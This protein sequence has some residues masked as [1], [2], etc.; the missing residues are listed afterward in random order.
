MELGARVGRKMSII[1]TKKNVQNQ[2]KVAVKTDL[3]TAD[4]GSIMHQAWCYPSRDQMPDAKPEASTART[5]ETKT[6]SAGKSAK[7]LY[8]AHQNASSSH[9][10][11]REVRSVRAP[12]GDGET[13]ASHRTRGSH[14]TGRTGALADRRSG[15][16]P[17]AERNPSTGQNFVFFFETALFFTN[18][19]EFMRRYW[20]YF[21]RWRREERLGGALV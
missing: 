2:N 4:T 12:Q 14:A 13:S 21:C 5:N 1:E 11:K 9:E 17:S 19:E 18:H 15:G 20:G 8:D 7:I 6:P 3:P 10:H 16:R